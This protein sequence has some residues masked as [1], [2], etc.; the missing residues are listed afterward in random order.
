MKNNPCSDSQC[1]GSQCFEDQ[2]FAD[3]P[4]GIFD[5]GVGGLSVLQ[6]IHQLLPSE[7]LL[8]VADSGH[9][10]YGCKDESYIEQRSRIITEYFL[11]QGSK[12]IVIACN[13]ATASIIEKF[14]QQ[15]GIPFIGV[16]PGIKPA[17]AMTE[18]NNVGIMATAGTLSSERY[19]EL[20]QRFISSVNLYHQA[21]PGLADQVE[22]GLLN[23]P[24]TIRLLEKYLSLLLA[25]QVDTIVLGC[26]HYSFLTKQI[27]KI[28]NDSIHLVDTSRA[29]AEQLVRVLEQ[30][31]LKKISGDGSIAYFTT[32][33]I[34]NTR[35][36]MKR[37]LNKEVVVNC[38][39]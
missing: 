16:E 39:P 9:A 1:S 22:A 37:L 28:I 32:G 19:N 13:T 25:R 6:H 18:N 31:A 15:Y 21:C 17:M 4:I 12:T 26:T 10:P 36:T 7:N 35:A 30:A 38:L 29:I 27:K 3:G 5:S 33:S 34:N 2:Q 20:S 11:S 23:A 24:E 14:R 8:Y